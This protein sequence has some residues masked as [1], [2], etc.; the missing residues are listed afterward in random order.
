MSKKL[1][2]MVRLHS[3]EREEWMQEIKGERQ[4]EIAESRSSKA[5]L[6][7]SSAASLSRRNECLE[8]HYSPIL[9][10]RRNNSC[11]MCQSLR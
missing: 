9:R 11:Q 3:E 2:E 10:E 6:A 7:N 5:R 1:D 4:Q 8:T